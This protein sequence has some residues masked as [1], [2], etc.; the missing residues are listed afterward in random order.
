[1]P[2]MPIPRNL[3]SRLLPLARWL[4][5]AGVPVP[6]SAA[7][8]EV[9]EATAAYRARADEASGPVRKALRSV[10]VC[11]FVVSALWWLQHA[12]LEGSLEAWLRGEEVGGDG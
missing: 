4:N 11:L 6:S 9:R 1:M 3:L 8:R 5:T 12:L 7:R 2:T 10:G